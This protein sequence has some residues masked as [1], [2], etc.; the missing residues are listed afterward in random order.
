[1]IDAKTLWDF[2]FDESNR[3]AKFLRKYESESYAKAIVDYIEIFVWKKIRNFIRYLFSKRYW[4]AIW[5]AIIGNHP[6]DMFELARNFDHTLIKQIIPWV[7]GKVWEY[8]MLDHEYADWNLKV[9]T[10]EVLDIGKRLELYLDQEDELYNRSM[11]F[12]RTDFAKCR[13]IMDARKIEYDNLR[14]EY[15]K[16]LSVLLPYM[17]I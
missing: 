15:M 3:F 11:E 17:W 10:D 7:I 9:L 12:V 16:K 5:Q 4:Y 8:T 6:I 2:K 13:E 14:L 1:M